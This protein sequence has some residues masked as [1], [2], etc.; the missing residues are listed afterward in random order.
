MKHE[1]GIFV[2]ET[3]DLYAPCGKSG[4]ENRL[5]RFLGFP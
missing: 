1:L 5:C 4:I 3:G 2:D